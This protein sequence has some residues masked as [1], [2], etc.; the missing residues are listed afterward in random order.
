[1]IWWRKHGFKNLWCATFSCDE[2]RGGR[3]CGSLHFWV[4]SWRAA[5]CSSGSGRLP[6][7]PRVELFGAVGNSESPAR[8]QAK[9]VVDAS[10]TSFLNL[11]SI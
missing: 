8:S 7:R 9:L 2:V 11:E 6:L 10:G 3:C 4:T 1:M 5:S